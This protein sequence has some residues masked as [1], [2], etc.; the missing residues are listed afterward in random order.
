MKKTF[1]IGV[2]LTVIGDIFLCGK[3]NDLYEILNF[4]T[5]VSLFTHQLPRAVRYVKPFILK[6]HPQLEEYCDKGINPENWREKLDYWTSV[7]GKEL[8]LEPCEYYEHKDPIEELEEMVEKEK[9]IVADL[10]EKRIDKIH[11]NQNN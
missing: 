10:R 2:V 9:I 4:M 11:P 8:E 1:K 3:V 7:F 6:Q 5:G